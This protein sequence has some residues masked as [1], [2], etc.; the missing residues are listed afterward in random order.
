MVFRYESPIGTL[1][2]VRTRSSEYSI[3]IDGIQYGSYTSAV[4]AAEAVRSFQT[5]HDNWDELF[6]DDEVMD[7]VPMSIGEWECD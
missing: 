1:R 4:A 7:N 6:D 2:I 3:V 5:E